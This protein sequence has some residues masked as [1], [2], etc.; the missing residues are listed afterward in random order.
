MIVDTVIS[1]CTV[2]DMFIREN[3]RQC[4]FFSKDIYIIASSHFFDGTPEDETKIE[5]LKE[6]CK[7]FPN[8][9]LIRFRWDNTKST[10]YWHSYMRWVGVQQCTTEW[11]MFMDSDE[12]FEGEIASQSLQDA[13]FFKQYDECVF[14]CYWYFREPVFRAKTTEMAHKLVRASIITK[15]DFLSENEFG[16]IGFS[17]KYRCIHNVKYNGRPILHHFSWVRTKE[18]MLRKTS[19]WAH[20][21]DK[22]WKELIEE[23]F[24][25]PFNGT[26]FVHGYEYD[27]INPPF[28]FPNE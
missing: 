18:E 2:D 11:I 21:N 28:E 10:S 16:W 8:V 14:S 5:A 26:D 12:I 23:E 7:Q 6:Y 15:K 20:K 17:G 9:H 24:S 22:N 25:R 4:L 3:I 27:I 19:S 1:Y 13:E